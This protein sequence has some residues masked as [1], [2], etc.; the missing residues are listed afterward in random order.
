MNTE[1]PGAVPALRIVTI[2]VYGYDE[3]TFFAAL[4]AAGVDVFCDLRARRAVRGAQYAFA[5]SRRLQARLAALGIAYRHY[6]ELAPPAALR[7]LQYTAD[8]SRGVG[9]RQRTALDP[10][11]VAIYEREVL[12]S[13]S[14]AEFLASL[15]AGAHVAALF[16][17]EREPAACHRALVAA[18]LATD[19]GLDVEHIRS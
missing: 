19:L 3:A 2:G 16:C 11:F 12:A 18:R 10:A 5:N 9:K 6:P 15:P 7:K 8:D 4:Q 14:P 13:F 17:V 1:L